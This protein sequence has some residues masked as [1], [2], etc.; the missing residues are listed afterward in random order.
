MGD[1]DG[2]PLGRGTEIVLHLKEDC[3]KYAEEKTLK[4]LIKKHSQFIGFPLWLQVTKEEEVE[5]EDEEED[6]PKDKEEDE[7]EENEDDDPK[8]EDAEEEV[9]KSKKKVKVSKQEM[10]LVNTQ[11]PIWTKKP[12]EVTNEEYAEFYKSIS[13]DWEDHLAVKHFSVEGQLE[14]SGLLFCP[15]RAPFDMFDNNK[16]KN[17]IKLYVRRVFIMDNCEDLM[18]NYLSFIKGV[19]DS[20]DLPLNISRETLQQS[21]ILRVINKNLVKKSI[22]MFNEL[23]ENEENYQKFYEAFS[24]PLKLGIHEDVKNKNKLAELL[25]FYSTTSGSEW[26]SLK[27]YVERMGE[28]QESIFYI[29]AETKV[30]AESSPFLEALKKRNLEVLYMTDPIDEHAVQ[31][32]KEYD[33]KKLVN[34][35]KEGLDLG[36]DE[37]EKT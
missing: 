15:K 37:D 7:A 3:K 19:V 22:E 4:D 12:D 27:E 8:I 14:F 13:N 30:L 9:E 10:E 2:E 28:T 34:V 29:T 35:T 25:R 1:E 5:A 6:E 21:K 33:G 23:A 32:L 18:P 16:Q 17:H 20:E 26:T 31:Q 36:L 24:K 11:K